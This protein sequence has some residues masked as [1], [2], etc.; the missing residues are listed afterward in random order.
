MAR[1]WRSAEAYNPYYL[2]HPNKLMIKYRIS[3]LPTGPRPAP[4]TIGYSLPITESLSRNFDTYM[5]EAGFPRKIPSQTKYDKTSIY[6]EYQFPM[7]SMNKD[8]LMYLWTTGYTKLRKACYDL[9]FMCQ[10]TSVKTI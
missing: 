5:C 3:P 10:L 1:I 2:D 7:K 6:Y 8:R 9:G 4:D